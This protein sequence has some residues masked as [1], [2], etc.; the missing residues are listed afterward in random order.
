MRV[1]IRPGSPLAKYR[2]ATTGLTGRQRAVA[3]AIASGISPSPLDD[4]IY[5]GGKVVP[6]MVFQN[7]YLGGLDSWVTADMERIDEAIDLAMTDRRLNNVVAQYFPGAKLSCD[8]LDS[9]VL[10]EAKPTVLDEP[11][12]Q[13]VVASLYDS[14]LIARSDLEATVFNL[15]VP[16]GCELKLGSDSSHDGLG[17]YHGSM[18]LKRSGKTVTLYYSANVY[19][20]MEPN[21]SEN[22]IVSFPHPWMNVVA[23]LY[24]ELNEFRTDPDVNDAIVKD[25]D[26]FLGWLSQGNEEI[27]DQP[28]SSAA[29]L[30]NVFKQVKATRKPNKR[31]PVQFL[32]SN[33][34]H[35]A[36]GPIEIP[37]G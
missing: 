29:D 2:Y 20:E 14:E 32:Y 6:H 19:S 23:T 16:S 11:D 36:E 17:G 8:M 24:H 7:V 12:V 15:V 34:V 26:S 27:G 9:F 33:A 28:L 4:L 3:T 35:G 10:D 37:H 18:H 1:Q 25:D 21:G 13:Q 22:G 5:H 30:A 31:V